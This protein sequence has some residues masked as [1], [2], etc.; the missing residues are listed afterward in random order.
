MFAGAHAAMPV[1]QTRLLLVIWPA[2]TALRSC[3]IEKGPDGWPLTSTWNIAS[4]GSGGGA[5]AA[6]A[7]AAAP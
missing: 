2:V 1:A 4:P 5:A 3:V 6:A 7:G